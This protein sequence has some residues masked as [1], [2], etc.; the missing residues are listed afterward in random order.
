MKVLGKNL[1]M[2]K[3]ETYSS[4]PIIKMKSRDYME[5]VLSGYESLEEF[6][7]DYMKDNTMY[8]IYYKDE[9]SAYLSVSKEGNLVFTTSELNKTKGFLIMKYFGKALEYLDRN[10]ITAYIDNGYLVSIDMA[11]KMG[12]KEVQSE[13]KGFRKFAYTR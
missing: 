4:L 3:Y 11:K 5:L 12:F 8:V 7:I 2:I 10:V 9:P 13:Y 6:L 1:N